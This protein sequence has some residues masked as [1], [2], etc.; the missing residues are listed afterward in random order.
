MFRFLLFAGLNAVFA[1]SIGFGES[2]VARQWN[3]E[4]LDAIRIDTPAPTVPAR[5]LFHTSIAMYDSWAG[6][7]DDPE[8]QYSGVDWI[9]AINWLPYQRDTFVTP[10]FAG[11]ISGDNPGWFWT[12]QD[13]TPERRFF[14]M[15]DDGSIFSVPEGLLA[16]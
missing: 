11:Y 5:N 6:Q 9:L 16:K 3:E 15:L 10:P 7:P 1:A 4:L 8:S 14:Q 2:T 13:N 12:F